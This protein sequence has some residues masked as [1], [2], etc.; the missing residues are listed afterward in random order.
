MDITPR[1]LRSFLVL[2]QERRFHLAANK[3]FITSSA[4]SQ[5][6]RQLESSLKLTLFDRTS[7]A[8]TLTAQGEKLV[9]LA[10]RAIDAVESITTWALQEK[11]GRPVLRVGTLSA[12][13]RRLWKT[14]IPEA[15]AAL[16]EFDVLPYH[17][18]WGDQFGPVLRGEVDLAVVRDPSVPEGLHAVPVGEESRV[19]LLPMGHRLA[20]EEAVS[21]ADIAGEVF[22]PPASGSKRWK[23]L[24]LAVPRS[25][26]QEPRVGPPVHGIEELLEL[27]ASGH[28]ISLASE[29]IADY[30][31]HPEVCCVSV[32]GLPPAPIHLVRAE[33]V[34][35]PYLLRLEREVGRQFAVESGAPLPVGHNNFR[36][37]SR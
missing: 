17:L 16:P 22:I 36:G 35:N 14:I 24:W 10:H 18:D 37:F 19:A 26:A 1:V 32:L 8:V 27:V 3:L 34:K 9:P 2:A 13:T 5:Q 6:I 15:T 11:S 30:L 4:L 20:S 7:R 29:G 28:G 33:S 23:D 25:D 21:V 31:S 12:D